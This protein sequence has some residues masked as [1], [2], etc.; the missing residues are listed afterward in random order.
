MPFFTICEFVV[1]TDDVVGYKQQPR[2]IPRQNA[3]GAANT[4]DHVARQLVKGLGHSMD[5]DLLSVYSRSGAGHLFA[6]EY[7]TNRHA[8][9]LVHA[10]RRDLVFKR[11]RL[12]DSSTSLSRSITRHELICAIYARQQAIAGCKYKRQRCP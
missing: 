4:G 7:I 8:I 6:V 10:G 9:W 11:R 3:V 1:C 12:T 2:L 5:D